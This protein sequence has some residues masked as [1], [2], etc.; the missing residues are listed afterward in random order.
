MNRASLW[1]VGLLGAGLT[2]CLGCTWRTRI[3]GQVEVG[4]RIYA[5][6]HGNLLL[7]AFPLR[8]SRAVVMISRHRDGE[9]IARVVERLGFTTVRGSSTRGGAAAIHEFVR[10]FPARPWVVTPDGPKGPRGAV[11]PGLVRLAA[12]TGRCIQPLVGAARPAKVFASWDRFVLPLPFARV[13][14][15]FGEPM[16]VPPDVDEPGVQALARELEQ[17]LAREENVARTTLASW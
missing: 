6:L 8:H 13:V 1:W 11:K 15:H 16:A 9:F 12:A 3:T 17:R 10:D 5:L 4:P 2:R 14:V 7:P